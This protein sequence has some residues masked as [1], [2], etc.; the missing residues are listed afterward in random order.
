MFTI[1][2][3]LWFIFD[4]CSVFFFITRSLNYKSFKLCIIRNTATLIDGLEV[5]RL[6]VFS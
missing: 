2:E 6:F 4:K 3:F 5:S 1:K